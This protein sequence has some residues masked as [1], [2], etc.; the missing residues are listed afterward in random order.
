M[1][2]R[3]AQIASGSGAELIG[4]HV[5]TPSARAGGEPAWLERQQRLLVALGGRYRRD[6]RPS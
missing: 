3:A 6:G 2:R 1:I 4:V 5:R